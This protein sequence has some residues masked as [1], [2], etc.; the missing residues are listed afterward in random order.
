MSTE[1]DATSTPWVPLGYGDY[2]LLL[3]VSWAQTIS[4]GMC[5]HLWWNRK[6]P[7][8]I[9]KNVDLV[10]TCVSVL[11]LC[12]CMPWYGHCD[13][14]IFCI[15]L[16]NH[17]HIRGVLKL[18]RR[19]ALVVATSAPLLRVYDGVVTEGGRESPSVEY[20]KYREGQENRVMSVAQE[21]EGIF[22]FALCLRLTGQTIE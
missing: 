16:G 6:W 22:P 18:S 19:E 15:F 11:L 14:L 17:E 1:N 5:V 7:P 4:L 21:S 20:S 8:Y 12:F 13:L 3:A 9:T 10:A 2:A